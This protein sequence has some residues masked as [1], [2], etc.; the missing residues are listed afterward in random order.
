MKCKYYLKIC[1]T[2]YRI[3]KHLSICKVQ[4]GTVHCTVLYN[5]FSKRN[6][7]LIRKAKA[8][9][10]LVEPI[11]KKKSLYIDAFDRTD[12]ILN[13]RDLIN[14]DEVA[15]MPGRSKVI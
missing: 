6:D 9:L 10:P 14:I 11:S 7:F 3:T 15:E 4:Q 1:K 5:N 12:P 13:T 2:T 8:M